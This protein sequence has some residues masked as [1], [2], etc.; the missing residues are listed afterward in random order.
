MFPSTFAL[1]MITSFTGTPI[2]GLNMLPSFDQLFHCFLC[3]VLY[4]VAQ[5]HDIDL[6]HIPMY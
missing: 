5:G 6:V 2:F 1:M 3:T 4:F